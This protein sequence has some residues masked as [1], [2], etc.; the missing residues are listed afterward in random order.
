MLQY[1]QTTF[2]VLSRDAWNHYQEQ[3]EAYGKRS[4]YAGRNTR[5]SVLVD[6]DDAEADD[7]LYLLGGDVERST[8]VRVRWTAITPSEL[9]SLKRLQRSSRF[10]VYL[11][12]NS[13]EAFVVLRPQSYR[14]LVQS[15][16]G[17]AMPVGGDLISTANELAL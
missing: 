9:V 10:V 17:A 8:G 1:D 3:Q 7:V 14:R 6:G 13:R 15:A 12:V 4:A 11:R 16:V 5:G 2:L